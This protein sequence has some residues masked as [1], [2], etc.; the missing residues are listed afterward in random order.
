MKIG[1]F[2][3]P[4][5]EILCGS[6]KCSALLARLAGR[7]LTHDSEIVMVDRTFWADL[8][9][10]DFFYGRRDVD[11]WVFDDFQWIFMEMGVL[12]HPQLGLRFGAALPGF[13]FCDK[14][15]F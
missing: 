13:F 9:L 6:K 11:Y 5:S 8:N 7:D 4:H 10:V 3:H 14:H 2:V 1:V 15:N 12:V